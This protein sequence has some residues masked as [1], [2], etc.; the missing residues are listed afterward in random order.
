MCEAKRLGLDFSLFFYR[1]S[2]R[3]T[4]PLRYGTQPRGR[5]KKR[6][7][8][9]DAL[10]QICPFLLLAA[11]HHIAVRGTG[12]LVVLEV[13]LPVELRRGNPPKS[14]REF[15]RNPRL[16]ILTMDI[17]GI[18]T[19]WLKAAVECETLQRTRMDRLQGTV[20]C[21]D[22]GKMHILVT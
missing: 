10:I 9:Y 18:R 4:V 17:A 7:I 5:Q 1:T 2:D 19:E 16:S 21:T 13:A 15:F 14:L 11:C 22:P 20:G 3:A 12:R 8:L 6:T